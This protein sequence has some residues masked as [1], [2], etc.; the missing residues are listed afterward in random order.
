MSDTYIREEWIL[1]KRYLNRYRKN[2]SLVERL[3]DKRDNLERRITSLKSPVISD[4]P[5]GGTPVRTEDL[6]AEKA[7]IEDRIER[8]TDKGLEYKREIL[9][10]IDELDDSRYAEILESYYVR[11]K[12]IGDIAEDTGYTVRHVYRLYRD[13]ITS[14]NIDS[15][16][17]VK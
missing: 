16:V 1:K 15:K 14:I 17:T 4:M 9:S 3:I 12:D 7:E 11:I 8:L 2:L 10:A 5:R 6:I 13:A